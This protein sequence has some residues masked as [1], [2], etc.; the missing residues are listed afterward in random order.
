MIERARLADVLPAFLTHYYESTCG[1]LRSLTHLTPEEAEAIQQRIRQEGN[2]FASRRAPDYLTVRRA[3][4]SQIRGLFTEKGGAP[5]LERP[6]YFILGDCPWL[7]SWYVQGC[8]LRLPIASFNPGA[9]SFTYGDS[10]PAMRYQDGKPY[11]GKVYTLEELPALVQQYGLPQQW[12]PDGSL[13]PERYIEAQVW[14]DDFLTT[15]Q[16]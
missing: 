16:A 14:E 2:R 5:R 6:H 13:G 11:R 7:Q 10:F 12:N 15:L 9:V 4:E 1:P 3:L 8:A